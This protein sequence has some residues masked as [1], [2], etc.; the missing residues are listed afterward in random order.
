MGAR[1]P[2]PNLAK[3]HRTYSVHEAA[4]LC[5]VTRNTIRRWI[6][7]G[8]TACDEHRPVIV[9]GA[10]LRMFLQDKRTQ[11]KRPCGPGRIYCVGCRSP[12]K[13]AGSIA[14][15]LP[16][17]AAGGKLAGICPDCGSMMYRRVSLAKLVSVRGEMDIM[18]TQPHSRIGESKQPFVKRD[19]E[20]ENQ[21]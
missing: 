2:N 6:K 7:R 15:Y 8:L 5:G 10:D 19:F 1:L 4:R 11:N 9:R 16:S 21:P 13:P 20:Q 17:T 12:K 18:V 14:D 3:I